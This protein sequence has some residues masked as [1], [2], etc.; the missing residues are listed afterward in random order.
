MHYQLPRFKRNWDQVHKISPRS[1]ALSIEI[2]FLYPSNHINASH[3][4]VSQI[5]WVWTTSWAWALLLFEHAK[6]RLCICKTPVSL[7]M[8]DKK[9]ASSVGVDYLDEHCSYLNMRRE[10]NCFKL[11]FYIRRMNTYWDIYNINHEYFKFIAW[12]TS[13]AML[14]FEYGIGSAISLHLMRS[15]TACFLRHAGLMKTNSTGIQYRR[16]SRDK[17]W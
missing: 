2:M 11:D 17:A 9:N 7:S 13:L 6:G 12:Y 1:H 14:L 4:L 5:L 8:I 15:L 10:A 3:S 16:T